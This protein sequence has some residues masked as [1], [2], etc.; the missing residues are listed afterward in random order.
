MRRFY[1]TLLL[2]SAPLVYSQHHITSQVA[3][4]DDDAEEDISDG[5]MDITSSDLEM[6]LEDNIWP[7]PNDDQVV[8]IR[9]D[10][11]NVPPGAII[12]SAHI[13]FTVDE[14]TSDPTVVIISG[15]AANN[16]V[17]FYSLDYNISQRPQT[18]AEV[19]WSVA[20]W[21]SGDAAGPDQAT[22]DIGSVVQEIVNR[23]GWQSGNAMV[24]IIEGS[25][26]RTAHSYDGDPGKAPV[27]NIYYTQ[28]TNTEDLKSSHISVHPNPANEQVHISGLPV[29]TNYEVMN[30]AGQVTKTGNFNCT[31]CQLSLKEIPAGV[32]FLKLT[33]GG[34]S[35][36]RKLV[37][38]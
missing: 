11:I 4:S 14:T 22:S 24:F 30:M 15:E 28:V 17:K 35:V 9:F 19:T 20:A 2:L 3:H 36:T 10:N 6:T 27:L 23:P 31:S 37:V 5:S 34:H 16:A 1:I 13:Q 33:H 7:V 8:G 32:Y 25:G 26:T 18:T 29:G 38:R 12:D 21:N